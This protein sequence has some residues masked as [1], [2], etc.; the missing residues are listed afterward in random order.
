[1]TRFRDPR[2]VILMLSLFA[3]A[4]SGAPPSR[5]EI[6]AETLS[7]Y[8]GPTVKEVDTTTLSNKVMCGYQGWFNASPDGAGKGWFHWSKDRG[9]LLP[10][11]RKN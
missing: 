2:A 7:P 3:A 9:L 6:L 1:M 11:Q 5:E 4:A 10:G 8:T